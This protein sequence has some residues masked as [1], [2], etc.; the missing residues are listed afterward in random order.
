MAAILQIPVVNT[1]PNRTIISRE[2]IRDNHPVAIAYDL[3]IRS[4]IRKNWAP[5]ISELLNA[6]EQQLSDYAMFLAPLICFGKPD[7]R[8][9]LRGEK[10]PGR[11][12]PDSSSGRSYSEF[13]K[14]ETN[15]D[16]AT[17]FQDIF[18]S[19]ATRQILL[20]ETRSPFKNQLSV[21]MYRGIFPIW[22]SNN[23]QLWAAFICAP[24]YA[25]LPAS[26]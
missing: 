21:T 10:F 5:S 19:I 22:N 24:K 4:T 14:A 25:E 13:L 1:L 15:I 6:N 18:G 20:A 16:P 3:Y 12:D 7:C 23:D 8:I 2:E 17:I 9:M 11:F 26:D